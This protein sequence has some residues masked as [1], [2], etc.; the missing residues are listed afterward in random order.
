[1][2]AGGR[3]EQ[4]I[5]G[6]PCARRIRQVLICPHSTQQYLLAGGIKMA[7]HDVH[8]AAGT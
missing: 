1:M 2:V 6:F 4:P 3:F 7:P 5:S 8:L